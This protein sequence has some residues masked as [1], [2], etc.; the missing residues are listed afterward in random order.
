[1]PSRIGKRMRGRAKMEMHNYWQALYHGKPDPYA[2][3]F[4]GDNIVKVHV[5]KYI[6]GE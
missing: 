5:N 1:M 3:Y 2:I 4:I 6:E